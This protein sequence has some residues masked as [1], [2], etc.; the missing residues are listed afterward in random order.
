[1]TDIKIIDNRIFFIILEKD[2][3]KGIILSGVGRILCEVLYKDSVLI[4]ETKKSP[5]NSVWGF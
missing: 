1:M 3:K 2:D 5:N 4:V